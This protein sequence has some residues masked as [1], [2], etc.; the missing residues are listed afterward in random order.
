MTMNPITVCKIDDIARLAQTPF[1]PYFIFSEERNRANG[2][3]II[4]YETKVNTAEKFCLPIPFRFCV[5]IA[6]YET[7]AVE[8]ER[9]G[10]T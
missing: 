5:Y 10:T 7:N 1:N 6:T 4:Q 2:I 8:R 9:I 3:M